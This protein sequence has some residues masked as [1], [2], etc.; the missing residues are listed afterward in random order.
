MFAVVL[1]LVMSMMIIL[2][3]LIGAVGCDRPVPH[4]DRQ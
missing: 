3:V 1:L 2:G 4:Q